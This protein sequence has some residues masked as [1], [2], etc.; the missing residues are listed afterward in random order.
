ML[1]FNASVIPT[2]FY[3]LETPHLTVDHKRKVDASQ[4]IC[5][6]KMLDIR[7]THKRS[8]DEIRKITNQ[9]S[10]QENAMH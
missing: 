2:L 5:M 9:K 7:W 6:R 1:L 3:A 10:V 4:N 8:N